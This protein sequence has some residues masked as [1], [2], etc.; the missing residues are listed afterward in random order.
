MPVIDT[1]GIQRLGI[2]PFK[3]WSGIGGP[4]TAQLTRYLT[5]KATAL[6]TSTGK[7]TVVA[8]ADPNADGVFTGELTSI[9]AKDTQET[10]E[11][12]DKDG[13]TYTK[14]TY[15]RD[16][17]IEFSYSIISSRTSMPVGK[18]LKKGSKN[19][20]SSESY[21][22]LDDVLILAKSIADSQMRGLSKDIVPYIVSEGR[23][24]M[25]E[26][27]KDKVL[28]NRMKTALALVKNGN[29]EEAIKQYDII[30]NETGS[31]AAMTNAGI[32]R[33]SIASNI[34]ANA[35]LSEIFNDKSGLADKAIKQA[36]D[37]LNSKLPPKTNISIMKTRSTERDMIDYVVDQLTKI[38]IQEGNITVIDRSA[39]A[40]IDA[41]QQFQ[42]SGNVSDESA[43]SIG[44]QLGVRYI[45]L[46]WISGEKSGRRLYTKVLNIETARIEYQNDFEI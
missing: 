14:I 20:T 36:F 32:L 35:Q 28:K 1:S 39:R 25:E 18:V 15:N 45:V 13:N 42:I 11:A 30:S 24:L 31:V 2:E 22:E 40:L 16:V 17:A 43:V 23:K 5:D 9:T 29:Y 3:N 12:K 33:Q 6:I 41:E 7:F 10:Q 37:A 4:I 44:K 38:I 19:S 26:T 21:Y 46:C 8:P 27:S 34:V